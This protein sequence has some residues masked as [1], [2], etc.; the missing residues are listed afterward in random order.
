MAES[1]V[2]NAEQVQS[3]RCT[4]V[5]HG[6]GRIIGLGW[7]PG[8]ATLAPATC[9]PRYLQN[10]NVKRRHGIRHFLQESCMV[11]LARCGLRDARSKLEPLPH[12][13]VAIVTTQ[14]LHE[15]ERASV[16][17]SPRRKICHTTPH[18]RDR[19]ADAETSAAPLRKTRRSCR[20]CGL[21]SH[22]E[23]LCT[24]CEAQVYNVQQV[25]VGS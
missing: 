22:L 23:D 25:V 10:A 3:M 1:E 2:R 17:P 13:Y 18:A 15:A 8:P 19:T 20:R 12:E 5:E 21:S 16:E 11:L 14:D 7:W 4:K 24:L 6:G 9:A